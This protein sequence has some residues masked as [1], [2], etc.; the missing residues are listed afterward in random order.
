MFHVPHKAITAENIQRKSSELI[1][2]FVFAKTTVS[3]IMHYIETDGSH[4]ASE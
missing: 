1:H 2:P 3:A 4:K